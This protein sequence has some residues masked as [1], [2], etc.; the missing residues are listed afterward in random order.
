MF[1]MIA[2]RPGE[3][4]GFGALFVTTATHSETKES[5]N[6]VGALSGGKPDR[7]F[8][9]GD[10][11]KGAVQPGLFAH[12]R[13][14]KLYR[15][16]RLVELY[17]TGSYAVW[18]TALYGS[19]DFPGAHWLRPLHTADR[20]GWCDPGDQDG[21]LRFNP[22]RVLPFEANRLIPNRFDD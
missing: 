1:T 16:N 21:S 2:V 13:T 14:G 17:K 12:Y 7:P 11:L 22:V 4:L 20:K 8:G 15:L 5:F 10:H 6:I 19:P 9:V 3:S 18:Y